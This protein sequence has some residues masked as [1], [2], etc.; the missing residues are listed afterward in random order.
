MV[1]GRRWRGLVAGAAVLAV[2]GGTVALSAGGDSGSAQAAALGAKGP[3]ARGT[4]LLM[5]YRYGA[6]GVVK[7][8]PRGERQGAVNHWYPKGTKVTVSVKN[9]PNA[10]FAEWAG[11]CKGKKHVCKV[12]MKGTRRVLAG[13]N[14]K[15]ER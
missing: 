10:I 6:H 9:R 12:T 13:F 3:G 2:T 8:S 15:D 5:V 7:V 11:N 1:V 4:V 14:T